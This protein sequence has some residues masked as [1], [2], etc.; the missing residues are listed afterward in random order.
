ML[1][2]ALVVVS[3]VAWPAGSFHRNSRAAY[4]HHQHVAAVPDP[5]RLVIEVHA[6]HGVRT[7]RGGLVLHLLQRDL[8][9][10]AQLA[11]VGGRAPTYDVAHT[12]EEITKDVRAQDRITG[13]NAQGAH[14]AP[15][16]DCRCG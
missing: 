7:Q 12:R 15:L 10:T 8:L 11:L 6:Y 9:R 5:D 3:M 2:A 4:T 1:N 13:N 14:R 16:R